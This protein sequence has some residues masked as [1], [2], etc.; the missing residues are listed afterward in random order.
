MLQNIDKP[1]DSE[2]TRTL[3]ELLNDLNSLI[4]LKNVKERVNNLIAYQK[5]QQLR[6][7]NNLKTS[8]NTLHLAFEHRDSCLYFHLINNKLS[9]LLLNKIKPQTTQVIYGK[10]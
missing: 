9:F 4:G 7:E 3:E 8:I 6:K 10:V 2:D 5:V 1:E